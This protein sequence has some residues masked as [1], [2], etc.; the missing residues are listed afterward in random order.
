MNL[1]KTPRVGIC[2]GCNIPRRDRRG[3]RYGRDPGGDVAY[4]QEICLTIKKGQ[5]TGEDAVDELL[6]Q[7]VTLY[8]VSI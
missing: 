5:P 8:S 1:G 2:P 7:T 6:V 3:S 4:K